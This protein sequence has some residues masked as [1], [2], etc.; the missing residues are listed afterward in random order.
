MATKKTLS[1]SEALNRIEE[2]LEKIEEGNME[3]DQLSEHLKEVSMLI[4]LCKGKIA[5]TEEEIN[6]IL[7]NIEPQ[8]Q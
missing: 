3:I 2:I 5:N 8:D 6:K 1:Y 7:Q 4:K